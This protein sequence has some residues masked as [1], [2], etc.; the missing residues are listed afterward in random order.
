[1]DIEVAPPIRHSQRL[2]Q[3]RRRKTRRMAAVDETL[4]GLLKSLPGPPGR[5]IFNFEMQYGQKI[6]EIFCFR[7]SIAW[8]DLMGHLNN[9][10]K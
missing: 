10:Q 7:L 4:Q 8:A 9:R 5:P 3:S 2:D 6:P 1:M